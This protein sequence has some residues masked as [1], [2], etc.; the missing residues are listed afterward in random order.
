MIVE[1]A[2]PWCIGPSFSHNSRRLCPHYIMSVRQQP[3]SCSPPPY[4]GSCAAQ[5]RRA[6]ALT[7]YINF[8]DY[9]YALKND[10]SPNMYLLRI[11]FNIKIGHCL[12]GSANL[13]YFD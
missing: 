5:G 6:A 4:L 10:C 12:F 7:P 9:L 11:T 8:S 3:V 1:P 13:P 2:I